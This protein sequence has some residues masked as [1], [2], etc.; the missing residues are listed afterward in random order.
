MAS[1][2]QRTSRNRDRKAKEAV[3][4]LYLTTTADE[5]TTSAGVAA[6]RSQGAFPVYQLAAGSRRRNSTCTAASDADASRGVCLLL[7]AT[8]FHVA[9]RGFQE[10]SGFR[11]VSEQPKRQAPRY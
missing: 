2:L 1:V 10:T 9:A 11:Y 4:G 3:G 8:E 5:H 7:K 6:Q